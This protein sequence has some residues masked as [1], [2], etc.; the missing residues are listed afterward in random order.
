MLILTSVAAAAG[1]IDAVAG[2][3]GLL[4]VPALLWSGMS[5]LQ[6][7]ATNKAQAVFGSFTAARHF[8]RRGRIELRRLAPAIG[9]TFVGSAIGTLCVQ[10]LDSD[11]LARL[12]PILLLCF[13]VYFLLSRRLGQRPAKQRI[14]EGAFALIIGTGLGFY[15]GFFGPGTGTFFA[16]AFILL[17]GYDLIR[18]TAGTKVLNFT[19]NFASFL[20]F[21]ASGQVIWP[22]GLAMGLAQIAG[23]RLGAHMVVRH[24][25]KLIRP[26]LFI[27]SASL[28]IKLLLD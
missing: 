5:P 2:G 12:V 19:S 24:G 14:G 17:L 7:L 23:A 15:D 1:F 16:A 21:A 11:F 8:V 18:A 26:L 10:R 9:L 27:V 22:L 28:S 3:G 25:G 20:F 13:A 4:T 6:A